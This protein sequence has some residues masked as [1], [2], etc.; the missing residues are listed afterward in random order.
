VTPP[1]VLDCRAIHA[2]TSLLTNEVW[3]PVSNKVAAEYDGLSLTV[4]QNMRYVVSMS[5]AL[6]SHEMCASDIMVGCI[7]LVSFASKRTPDVRLSLVLSRVVSLVT[8]AGVA[9]ASSGV[10]S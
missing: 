4:I 10:R 7:P 8:V 3:A 2:A 6:Q 1:L 5:C 9:W